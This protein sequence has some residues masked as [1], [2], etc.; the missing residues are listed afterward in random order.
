MLLPDTLTSVHVLDLNGERQVFVVMR[1]EDLPA[2]E[3][4]ELQAVQDS[5]RIGG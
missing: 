1:L 5:I 3:R 2:A 4:A